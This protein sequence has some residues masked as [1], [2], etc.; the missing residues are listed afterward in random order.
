MYD[1][2]F[3]YIYIFSLIICGWGFNADSPS[4]MV[5]KKHT[6]SAIAAL[7]TPENSSSAAQLNPWLRLHMPQKFACCWSSSCSCCCCRSSWRLSPAVV[8]VANT[9]ARWSTGSCF[10][11]AAAG[12]GVA[13]G[14]SV[15]MVRRLLSSDGTSKLVLS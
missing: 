10:D 13:V 2:L 8:V 9:E 3:Y 7:S 1:T 15:R 4:S 12:G 6:W 14:G 5:W 11:V